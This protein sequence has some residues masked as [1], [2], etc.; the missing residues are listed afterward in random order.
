[1]IRLGFNYCVFLCTTD[2]VIGLFDTQHIFYR[3]RKGRPR[4]LLKHSLLDPTRWTTLIDEWG[5]STNF[6]MGA[7]AVVVLPP[8]S[9]V[10]VTSNV[11]VILAADC[12]FVWFIAAEMLLIQLGLPDLLEFKVD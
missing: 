7:V 10:S 5:L 1:M 11:A 3:P 4:R 2:E 12:N 9:T 8:G 6:A